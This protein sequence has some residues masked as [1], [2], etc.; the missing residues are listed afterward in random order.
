MQQ[1]EKVQYGLKLMILCTIHMCIYMYMYEAYP[2]LTCYFAEGD[3]GHS[4]LCVSVE[5]SNVD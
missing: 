2:T 1:L 3:T 5:G 4:V